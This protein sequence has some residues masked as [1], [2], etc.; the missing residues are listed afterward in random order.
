MESG[1]SA[2]VV[3]AEDMTRRVTREAALYLG[4]AAGTNNFVSLAP[5][6]LVMIED[7]DST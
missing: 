3:L 1:I 6:T 4:G 7:C 2:S 5:Y